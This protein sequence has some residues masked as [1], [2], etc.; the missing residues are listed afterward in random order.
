[1][2]NKKLMLLTGLFLVLTLSGCNK[3]VGKI[4]Q[5]DTPEEVIQ[6]SIEAQEKVHS[7]EL[8]IMNEGTSSAKEVVLTVDYETKE[9]NYH[10]LDDGM[11]IYFSDEH[12]LA[13]YDDGTVEDMQ[14]TV[15]D[16]IM[17][18]TEADQNPLKAYT[19]FDESFYQYL[20]MKKKRTILFYL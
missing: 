2:F 7:M 12:V 8:T 1:M 5:K 19:S 18:I 6:K 14:N 11:L 16:E 13:E 15:A 17:E 20:D 9:G 4:L 3:L 10:L